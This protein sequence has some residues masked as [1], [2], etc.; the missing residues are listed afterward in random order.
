MTALAAERDTRRLSDGGGINNC[1]TYPIKANVKCY[2]GGIALLTAALLVQ[3]GATAA[4]LTIAGKF[5]ETVDNTGGADGAASVKVELGVFKW[6][7]S[8]AL[9]TNIGSSNAAIALIPLASPTGQAVTFAIINP[10]ANTATESV[11]VTAGA[12]AVTTRYAGGAITSTGAQILAAVLGSTAAMA[13]LQSATLASGS[14]GTGTVVAVGA[15]AIPCDQVA[16]VGATAYVV[17]DQTLAGT[18]GGGT[19]SGNA[20]VVAVDS[21]GVYI[22]AGV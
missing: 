4:S 15:T 14:D 21:D 16:Q 20:T 12:I 6:G 1:R 18:T 9:A 11:A 3:P 2:K 5:A 8:A 22:K 17:D 19:R 10:G 7:N 13:L